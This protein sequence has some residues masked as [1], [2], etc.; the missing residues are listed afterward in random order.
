MMRFFAPP[1][2]R[3][4]DDIVTGFAANIGSTATET[5]IL[6]LAEKAL[7][8]LC[9][10]NTLCNT[11]LLPCDEEFFTKA[12]IQVEEA[13]R[14]TTGFLL[15]ARVRK[16]ELSVSPGDGS[17]EKSK[18]MFLIEIVKQTLRLICAEGLPGLESQLVTPDTGKSIRQYITIEAQRSEAEGGE[19]EIPTNAQP[20]QVA[21]EEDMKPVEKDMAKL[22]ELAFVQSVALYYYRVR[23]Y[24]PLL[25]VH[26]ERSTSDNVVYPLYPVATI[27]NQLNSIIDAVKYDILTNESRLDAVMQFE[28]GVAS[29]A[30]RPQEFSQRLTKIS[31]KITEDIRVTVGYSAGKTPIA[32]ANI[33]M[34]I[35]KP[36]P[37]KPTIAR[38]NPALWCGLYLGK[39]GREPDLADVWEYIKAAKDKDIFNAATPL[40]KI[41]L[42]AMVSEAV[43]NANSIEVLIN[44]AIAETGYDRA[45]LANALL[46]HLKNENEYPPLQGPVDELL[47]EYKK[48]ISGMDGTGFPVDEQTGLPFGLLS[49]PEDPKFHSY[50]PVYISFADPEIHVILSND[51]L[52]S[53]I[54]TGFP[55]SYPGTTCWNAQIQAQELARLIQGL[56]AYTTSD[57]YSNINQ[58]LIPGTPEEQ[59]PNA[60]NPLAKTGEREGVAFPFSASWYTLG[61]KDDGTSFAA[62]ADDTDCPAS[63][64]YNTFEGFFLTMYQGMNVENLPELRERAREAV[65]STPPPVRPCIGSNNVTID[66]RFVIVAE[67]EPGFDTGEIAAEESIIPVKDVW[68]IASVSH[69]AWIFWTRKNG[70]YKENKLLDKWVDA[71][72]KERNDIVRDI[73]AKPPP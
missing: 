34:A 22:Q 13:V 51:I 2:P 60:W 69:T 36:W 40:E 28:T 9:K 54:N 55:L 49:F 12:R 6:R 26:E 21:L 45:A 23:S 1:P 44:T 56:S 8:R 66:K 41:K 64:L 5:D 20:L 71:W 61:F 59:N 7:R 15:A 70:T 63:T 35:P 16:D 32:F 68:R 24:A 4:I 19:L 39:V 43:L 29:A 17:P 72:K 14:Q 50:L 10:S 11:S 58:L 18:R 3:S 38:M 30:E 48:I 33:T 57:W 67:R 73:S 46:P 47:G 52:N 42:L 65:A 37:K 62:K 31:A 25:V 27:R 53:P